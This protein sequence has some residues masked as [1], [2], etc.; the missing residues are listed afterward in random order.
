[1]SIWRRYHLDETITALAIPENGRFLVRVREP[2]G[3]NRNPIEFYRWNL[4]DAQEA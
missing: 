1:M 3:G 4:L 2:P